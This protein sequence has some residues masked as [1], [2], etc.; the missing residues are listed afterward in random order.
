MAIRRYSSGSLDIERCEW[1]SGYAPDGCR[2][3][4]IAMKARTRHCNVLAVGVF[5]LFHVGHVKLLKRARSLGTRLCV[6]VNGDDLTEKYKRRPVFDEHCRLEIIKACRFVDDAWISNTFD[7][8]PFIIREDIQK[9]VHGDEWERNSYL[10]QL[11]VD[12]TFLVRRDVELSLLP[13]T[14]SISTSLILDKI[15]SQ[16]QPV[17]SKTAG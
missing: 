6:V 12:E 4:E 9:I 3:K 17:R 1:T 5:D 15:V 10:E 2:P 13:Y 14:A 8:K 7:I 16:H 11:Q